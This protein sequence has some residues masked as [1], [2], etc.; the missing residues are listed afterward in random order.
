M[1]EAEKVDIIAACHAVIQRMAPDT[2]PGDI[3]ERVRFL[4]AGV[5]TYKE[6]T[7]TAR[8]ERDVA[9]RAADMA[10]ECLEES[11][12]EVDDLETKLAA[13]EAE[14]A[15]ALEALRAI[16]SISTFRKDD[17]TLTSSP[18]QSGNVYR[19]VSLAKQALSGALELASNATADASR[20]YDRVLRERDTLAKAGDNALRRLELLGDGQCE[21]AEELR[22]ALAGVKS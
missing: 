13:S 12:R 5:R 20:I 21:Q 17:V 9:T 11:T 4:C 2:P 6:S 3:E 22:E 8:D 10:C 18:A 16:A 14:H 15:A 1:S 7:E 19:A